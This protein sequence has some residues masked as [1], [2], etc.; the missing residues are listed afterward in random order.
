M[1]SF[2]NIDLLHYNFEHIMLVEIDDGNN[3]WLLY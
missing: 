2:W 3:K 1:Y